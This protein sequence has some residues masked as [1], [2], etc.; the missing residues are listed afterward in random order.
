VRRGVSITVTEEDNSFTISREV[1][2]E[3]PGREPKTLMDI[4]DETVGETVKTLEGLG[5]G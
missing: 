4:L 2:H 5:H 3:W 1:W